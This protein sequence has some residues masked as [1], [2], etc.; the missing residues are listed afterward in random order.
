MYLEMCVCV[1]KLV[2]IEREFCPSSTCLTV[3]PHAANDDVVWR[4]GRNA[5]ACD[6]QYKKTGLKNCQNKVK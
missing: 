3:I 4:E 2:P 6:C 1:P 5:I